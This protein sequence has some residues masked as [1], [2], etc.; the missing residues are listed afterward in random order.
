MAV[1][2]VTDDAYAPEPAVR[3]YAALMPRARLE[4]WSPERAGVASLGH[5]GFFRTAGRRLW[6]EATAHLDDAVRNHT[7]RRSA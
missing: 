5:F 2:A 6:D 4:L 7:T 1:V 3:A